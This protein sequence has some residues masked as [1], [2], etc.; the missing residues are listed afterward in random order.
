[1]NLR[2]VK[3]S[4]LPLVPIFLIF[5]LIHAFG[6]GYAL[7]THSTNYP[8]IVQGMGQNIQGLSSQIGIWG[9]IFLV[10]HAYS[11]GAG[12]FTGIEAVSNGLPIL[13]EPRVQTAKQ[14]MRYMAISLSFMAM[15]L[16]LSYVLYQVGHVP[17]K[18]LNAILFERIAADW[19]EGGRATFV[20][21]TLLSEAVILFVAAQTGFLDGPRVLANMAMDRWV[22]TRFA[23][24]SDRLVTQNGVL[25]MGGVALVMMVLTRGSVRFLVVLY[26]I[27]VFITFTL[28]QMGMVRHWWN[29][30]SPHTPWQKGLLINGIGLVL[31]AFILGAVTI[32]KF[33]E[34]GWVTLLITGALI[35]LI[36]VFRRHYQATAQLLRRLD[37]LLQAASSSGSESQ[38]GGLQ[39]TPPPPEIDSRGKAAVLL[40]NGFNGVGLHTLFSIFRLYGEVFKNFLFVEIGVLDAGAFKGPGSIDQL[41]AQVRQDLD[42]YVN[43]VRRQGFYGEGIFSIGVD[44]VEEVTHLAP[45][46]LERFPQAV[47]IGGQLVFPEDTFLSRLLHN[48]TLFAIQRR[49]YHGGIPFTILPIRVSA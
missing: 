11:M 24:L 17:G 48:Y 8:E 14:T 29:S 22:P 2:G 45:K 43:F 3:E 26:S 41:E 21:V 18:T 15:G 39:R 9:V 42:R 23:M 7:V 32:F 1:L 34:G 36:I 25:I 6:I 4:V 16:M 30:R 47:F 46:I 13:R 19:G 33:H 12:T 10:L 38:A 28:S 40:V 49:L 35:G 20:L 44:V 5:I 37:P 31:S 27:N